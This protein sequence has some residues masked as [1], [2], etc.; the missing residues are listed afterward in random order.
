MIQRLELLQAKVESK[1]SIPIVLDLETWLDSD[2]QCSSFG[3][4]ALNCGNKNP[5]ARIIIDDMAIQTDMYIETGLI[6]DSDKETIRSFV[7]LAIQDDEVQYMK[8][9]I[10]LFQTWMAV[11]EIHRKV[12]SELSTPFY[13]DFFDHYKEL[14]VE[15][16]IERYKDQRFFEPQTT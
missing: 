1:T 11:D 3:R 7:N 5:N 10:E 12:L 16:L 13:L 9:Y 4:Y 2:D 14:S 8:A 6:L 15:E